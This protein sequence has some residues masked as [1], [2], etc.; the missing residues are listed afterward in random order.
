MTVSA[1][2]AMPGDAVPQSPF[3]HAAALAAAAIG[4]GSVGSGAS[5]VTMTNSSGN[6]TLGTSTSS[7]SSITSHSAAHL[8]DKGYSYASSAS[9]EGIM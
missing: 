9:G 4:T 8:G 7:M 2:P 6:C 5:Q 3:E 1:G